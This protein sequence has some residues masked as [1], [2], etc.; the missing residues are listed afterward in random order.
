MEKS[1]P[2]ASGRSRGGEERGKDV[3]SIGCGNA[4]SVVFD[5]NLYPFFPLMLN[6]MSTEM[7]VHIRPPVVPG[8]VRKIGQNGFQYLRSH[9]HRPK[10]MRKIERQVQTF[11]SITLCNPAAC[12]GHVSTLASWPH[13]FRPC[14]IKEF[15]HKPGQAVSILFQDMEKTRAFLDRHI[16]KMIL[17]QLHGPAKRGKGGF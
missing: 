11:R 15:F 1:Q 16:Y 10:R 3:V 8:I 12:C 14:Q 6:P 9:A 5:Q 13:Y 7:H 4:F 17:E 2:C